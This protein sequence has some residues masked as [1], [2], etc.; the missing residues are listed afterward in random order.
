MTPSGPGHWGSVLISD[1]ISV[2]LTNLFRFPFLSQFLRVQESV[3][4]LTPTTP[5]NVQVYI[6]SQYLYNLFSIRSVVESPLSFLIFQY[7]SVSVQLKICQIFYL[8]K[9][10][11]FGFT[12]SLYCFSTLYFISPPFFFLSD[13]ETKYLIDLNSSFLI[14][15]LPAEIMLLIPSSEF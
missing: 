12:D 1:R 2:L 10:P 6:C 3:H 4:L 13:P 15:L 9:K 14:V 8:F 5:T 11:T 7:F